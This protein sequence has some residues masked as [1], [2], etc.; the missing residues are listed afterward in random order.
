[1]LISGT[2]N[3]GIG[4]TSPYAKLSVVGETV[5]EYFTATSTTATSTIMGPL[6]IGTNSSEFKLTIDKDASTPDGGILS[7]GTLSSGNTLTTS[8]AGTRLIWYPQK[9]AFRAGNINGT[10]WDDSNI[11]NYSLATGRDTKASGVQSTALGR[12]TTASGVNSTA[13]GYYNT[14]SGNE[15]FT[16]TNYLAERKELIKK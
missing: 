10:Q 5:A 11:G 6:G 4:T 2:G 14:S 7:I 16:T 3:V 9:A 15:S 13:I 1:M 8:G 12:Q